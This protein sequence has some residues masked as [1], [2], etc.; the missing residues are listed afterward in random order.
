MSPVV[1]VRAIGRVAATE[2]ARV[3]DD[4]KHGSVSLLLL[5]SLVDSAV[6]S[7]SFQFR[8]DSM[9]R[10]ACRGRQERQS[11]HRGCTCRRHR[12]SSMTNN[13]IDDLLFDRFPIVVLP[14]FAVDRSVICL[15]GEAGAEEAARQ[16]TDRRSATTVCLCV[17]LRF[18]V[19]F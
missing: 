2:A 15:A 13:S 18:V 8:L 1:G 17:V 3:L 19:Y 10:V 12:H 14:L 6:G 11:A 5:L 9:Q 16:R 4:V 7:V